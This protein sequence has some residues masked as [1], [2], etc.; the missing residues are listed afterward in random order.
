MH[1]IRLATLILPSLLTMLGLLV[2]PDSSLGQ[3]TPPDSAEAS[4]TAVETDTG[5][6]PSAATTGE[7][8]IP[9][10]YLLLR[11]E[12]LTQDELLTEVT[13]WQGLLKSKIQE[14]S[15]TEITGR[16]AVG[17][18]AD[19][20]ETRQAHLKTINALRGE[21]NALSE[22]FGAVV[23]AFE[24]K[25]GDPAE[26]RQY[27]AATMGMQVDLSDGTAVW[28]A[29]TNWLGSE[30][31]GKLW[32]RRALKF[33]AIIGVFW[34]LAALV[35]RVVRRAVERQP[36]FSD[37]LKKFLNKMVKRVILFI[38]LLVAISSMGINV[39]A[40]FALVGGGAF[41]IGFAL[42]DTLG[43][44]AAGVMV[45]I[46]RPFDVGDAVE[47]GG[48]SGKVDSVSLVS[49]TIR[50]F[51]NKRVL[52]PNQSVWGQ[53]ITNATASTERRVDL[54]FGIGYDDDIEKAQAI[55]ERL[56]AEHELVL[57]DPAPV[58]KVH[59]LADSSVN[60]VCRPWTRTEDY[61]TV[62][63]D[64][65]RQVKDTFDAEGVSI[66]YPQM[67]VHTKAS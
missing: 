2:F 53:V 35:G 48:V 49:T 36:A 3:N 29:F 18:G 26:Y 45:L 1:S 34:V 13:G 31:G 62:Y 21:K 15:E 4:A 57:E 54:V 63:W 51:D 9:L 33:L 30:S 47:V 39:S 19:T 25:G 56:V 65:T 38:G 50:T 8:G 6:S 61:W 22:R 44:F 24:E 14:I 12:P 43:N 23:D 52:V 66:P 41:V 37:L 59:E 58:I 42:Q 64:L 40:L 27:A 11:L 16:E 32:L 28:A 60:F 67:D 20:P 5:S 10:E 7:P 46:Y 17:T 55:L